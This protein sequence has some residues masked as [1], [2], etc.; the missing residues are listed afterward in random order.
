M[1]QFGRNAFLVLPITTQLAV[2]RGKNMAFGVHGLDVL[3][4][5]GMF[6]ELF[7]SGLLEDIPV[8]GSHLL[9]FL[10]F[11]VEGGELV[12]GVVHLQNA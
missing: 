2:G 12:Q 9:L 3:M 7:L 4:G 10:L 11:F 6:L 1:G 8:G 5:T